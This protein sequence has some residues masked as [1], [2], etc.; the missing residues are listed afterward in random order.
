MVTRR[1]EALW[2][3]LEDHPDLLAT[4]SEW[5]SLLGDDI[6]IA[7]KWLIATR[8]RATSWECGLPGTEGCFRK[9]VEHSPE[10]IVAVCPEGRCERVDLTRE[11]LVLLRLDLKRLAKALC[12]AVGI[13]ADDACFLN[14]DGGNQPA[15]R[16]GKRRFGITEAAFYFFRAA[17]FRLSTTVA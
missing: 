6:G 15:V 14:S 16:L 3:Q 4:R 13:D 9:V 1:L 7:T 8:E 5:A 10:R 11:Q 2:R 12:S 17:I